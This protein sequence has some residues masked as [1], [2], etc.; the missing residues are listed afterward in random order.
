MKS[1]YSPMHERISDPID[2]RLGLS[3]AERWE[4][5]L[6][7]NLKELAEAQAVAYGTA[8]RWG[9][10]PGFPRVGRLVR[11]KD[12]ESWWKRQI[13]QASEREGKAEHQHTPPRPQPSISGKSDAPR[14]IRDSG[15]AWPQRAALLREII[16]SRKRP[17]GSAATLP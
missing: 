9:Q 6:P 16:S 11:R 5:N 3:S 2:G 14:P 10:M 15:A 1:P 7:M 8:F 12:F 13:K 17:S 4:R